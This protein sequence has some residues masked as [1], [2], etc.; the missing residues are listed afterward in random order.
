MNLVKLAVSSAMMIGAWTSLSASP[1][2]CQYGK[3]VSAVVGFNSSATPGLYCEQRS[4]GCVDQKFCPQPS[5]VLCPKGRFATILKRFAL[6]DRERNL[7][8]PQYE[9]ACVDQSVC[10]QP[11]PILCRNGSHAVYLNVGFYRSSIDPS[12]SCINQIARC[13]SDN[14]RDCPMP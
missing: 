8:C 2:S 5:P 6:I 1:M 12:V 11:G 3:P 14:R 10:Q 7:S 9:G 4:G 13:V